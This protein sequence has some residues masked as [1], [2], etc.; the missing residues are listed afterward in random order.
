MD[1]GAGKGGGWSCTISTH[2]KILG[3]VLGTFDKIGRGLFIQAVPD[4]LLLRSLNPANSVF[5]MCTLPISLFDH[6][7]VGE[8]TPNV[9]IYLK[10][11]TAPS[12][13]RAL[14]ARPPRNPAR[15]RGSRPR[16]L[17]PRARARASAARHRS[18]AAPRPALPL[19]EREEH[20]ARADAR[21]HVLVRARHRALQQLC[22]RPSPACC[23]RPSAARSPGLLRLAACR[24]RS[25]PAPRARARA[26]SVRRCAALTKQFD[27][28]YEEEAPVNAMYNLDA[29]EHRFCAESRLLLGC[30]NNLPHSEH[31]LML[32]VT[33]SEL[34]IKNDVDDSLAASE[35]RTEMTIAPGDLH[36]WSIG[37]LATTPLRLSFMTREF[38]AMLHFADSSPVTVHF[39]RGGDPL[40]AIAHAGSGH[41][42]AR[43]EFVIATSRD[44]SA[45]ADDLFGDDDEFGAQI[46][47]QGIGV[48]ASQMP[49]GMHAG[50]RD[51]EPA[52]GTYPQT[53]AFGVASAQPFRAG[54]GTAAPADAPRAGFPSQPAPPGT[55]H[56]SGDTVDTSTGRPMSGGPRDA[57]RPTPQ[58]PSGQAELISSFP[59]A[60]VAPMMAAHAHGAHDALH[61]AMEVDSVPPAA[62]PSAGGGAGPTGGAPAPQQG[63][64]PACSDTD[65][66][67]DAVGATP[68]DSPVSKRPCTGFAEQF[69]LPTGP[70]CGRTAS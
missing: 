12:R 55:V 50:E 10:V 46:D 34:T 24:S 44:Q 17:V 6:F 20:D 65:N 8:D 21:R 58:Q 3:K 66:D 4:R 43:L 45:T 16:P 9:K 7:E 36:E 40:I 39:D 51:F 61:A 15:A 18:R 27:L 57:Q 69:A 35:V 29:C 60:P 32:S 26:P 25:R 13:D 42:R 64:P 2:I 38:K 62:G 56:N 11:R 54:D 1:G 37:A 14:R 70:S 41:E 31:E 23:P 52:G 28:S 30:V 67:D 5:C 49:S 33:P 68:P 59:S 19:A 63:T 47:P 22:V 48:N 53:G